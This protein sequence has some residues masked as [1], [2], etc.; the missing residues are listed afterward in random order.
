MHEFEDVMGARR[1]LVARLT[2]AGVPS[3]E[4]D[5]LQLLEAAL[6]VERAELLLRPN[7]TVSGGVGS[8]LEEMLRRREAREPLQLIVGHAHFYGLELAVAPGVLIPRPETERLVELVLAELRASPHVA[9]PVV[10]DVGCGTGAI[11]LALGAELPSAEVWGSDLSAEALALARRNAAALG[12]EARFRSSD[13]LGDPEV[14]AVAGRCQA[15][16]SNPPYL[17]DGDRGNLAPEV[18]ADPDDALF[19]GDDGLAVARRLVG[20][21]ERLLPAGALL[22]LELDPRNVHELAAELPAWSG[23][24]VE[25]DLAGRPR[26]LLARR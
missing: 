21:A 13:L 17:P 22:A 12:L 19:A 15:L 14:A 10:L 20:Q 26:F 25:D 16:V 18:E 9:A 2:A 23:V 5:A 8:R 11:A 7:A 1:L 4:A 6:G 3:P 24:R